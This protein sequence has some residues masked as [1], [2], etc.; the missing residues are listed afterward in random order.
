VFFGRES[1]LADALGTIDSLRRGDGSRI[2]TIMAASG[3]G[4]SSFLRAGLWPRLA[5]QSGVAPLVILRPG[6]G[7]ISA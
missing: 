5:R 1:R 4:K 2:L 3:V 7:I 6:A